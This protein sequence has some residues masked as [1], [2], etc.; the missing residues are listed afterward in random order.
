MPANRYSSPRASRYSR[1]SNSEGMKTEGKERFSNKLTYRIDF[2]DHEKS[3]REVRENIIVNNERIRKL[4]KQLKRRDT[5]FGIYLDFRDVA[6]TKA[7]T[8][9]M[10]FKLP[11]SAQ[12]L[13]SELGRKVAPLIGQRGKDIMRRYSRVETGRM[14]SSIVYMQRRRGNDKVDIEIGWVRRWH[15]YFGWQEDGTTGGRGN[16]KGIKPMRS[17][18]RTMP[19]LDAYAGRIISNFYS[20][21]FLQKGNTK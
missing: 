14:R 7:G 20:K 1:G 21:A 10:D 12:F 8:S 4:E 18:A 3:I 5:G 6:P 17:I 9:F 19:E 16:G 15:K 11:N 2:S 13:S